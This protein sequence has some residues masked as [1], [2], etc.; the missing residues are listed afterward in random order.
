MHRYRKSAS[1]RISGSHIGKIACAR[2]WLPFIWHRTI[3]P[4]TLNHPNT[5]FLEP[6]SSKA[7]SPLYQ[8]VIEQGAHE[9]RV[10]LSAVGRSTYRSR[11]YCV[12]K[13][14]PIY[15]H[16]KYRVLPLV[17]IASNTCHK[18]SRTAT[19]NH[20]LAGTKREKEIRCKCLTEI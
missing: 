20:A 10:C 2:L 19:V 11:F 18:R 12:A 16:I 5:H 1:T 17:H 14:S 15:V 4:N 8:H 6:H 13:L 3:D 9:H 7:P